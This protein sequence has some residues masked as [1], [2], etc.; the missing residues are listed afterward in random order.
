MEKEAI[1]AGTGG[2]WGAGVQWSGLAALCAS[3]WF[4]MCA[5]LGLAGEGDEGVCMSH[6]LLD[7]RRPG[8]RG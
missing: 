1:K 2:V 4:L 7:S 3:A 5:D 6:S 8:G